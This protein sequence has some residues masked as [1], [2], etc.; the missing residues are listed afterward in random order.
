MRAVLLGFGVLIAIATIPA[1]APGQG[2][3]DRL[4]AA[5]VPIRPTIAMTR[6]PPTMRA[7]R[8]NARRARAAGRMTMSRY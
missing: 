2:Y 7:R 3:Y 6:G 8:R 1:P 4:Y 5:S